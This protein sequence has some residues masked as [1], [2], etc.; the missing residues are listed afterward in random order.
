MCRHIVY[1]FT[2]STH[3]RVDRHMHAHLEW[4]RASRNRSRV[5]CANNV[6]EGICEGW[7]ELGIALGEP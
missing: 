1:V 3:F 7:E 6:S 4:S 2:V 5:S